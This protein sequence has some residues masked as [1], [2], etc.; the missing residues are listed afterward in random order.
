[1]L[2][3]KMFPRFK[4]DFWITKQ[5]FVMAIEV[6]CALVLTLF[7]H[8]PFQISDVMMMVL[9]IRSLPPE[10]LR[11]GIKMESCSY[12]SFCSSTYVL[13]AMGSFVNMIAWSLTFSTW[14][15]INPYGFKVIIIVNV[16]PLI[17]ITRC[18]YQLFVFFLV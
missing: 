12:S 9:Q 13:A 6:L 18:S 11:M 17:H 3:Y 16:S 1:M 10:R 14:A 15:L 5:T 8:S 7:I 2:V 4:K